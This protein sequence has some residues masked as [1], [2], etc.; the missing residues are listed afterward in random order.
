MCYNAGVPRLWDAMPDNV[1][2]TINAMHLNYLETNPPPTVLEKKL[3]FT[4]PVPGAEK[5]GDRCC[6]R[7]HILVCLLLPGVICSSGP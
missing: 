3:P 1:K 2:C 4:K 5:A 6:G 7:A